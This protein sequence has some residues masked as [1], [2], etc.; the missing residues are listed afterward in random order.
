MNYLLPSTLRISDGKAVLSSFQSYFCLRA[1]RRQP[2][3]LV[4][5]S[6]I[7]V[8]L[9]TAVVPVAIAVVGRKL[10]LG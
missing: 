9:F 10:L 1:V 8:Y 3:K 7:F 4:S 6:S 5:I 2:R